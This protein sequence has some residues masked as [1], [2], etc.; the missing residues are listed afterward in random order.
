[1]HLT[2]RGDKPKCLFALWGRRMTIAVLALASAIIAPG[3][4]KPSETSPK[5]PTGAPTESK[6]ASAGTNVL[7]ISMDTTRADYLGCYGHPGV[8]TPHIDRLASQGTLFLNCTASVPVT[9]PSH[10]SIMTG[11][12]PFVHGVRDNGPFQLHANNVTLAEVLKQKGYATAAE[13]GAFV[14]N[15]EFGLDQGFDVYKDIHLAE[16][17]EEDPRA[18]TYTERRAEEISSSAIEWL[19]AHAGGPFFLFVHYFDPHH[20]HDP[21]EEFASQYSDLYLA[22]IAYTDAQIGRLLAEL[23]ALALSDKTLVVLVG[24]HGEGRGQHQENTHA[25]YVYDSTLQVPLIFRFPG[26]I[27]LGQRLE[28]QT[29]LVDVAPTIL[30][31]LGLE[32]LPNAQGVSLMPLIDRQTDDLGLAAYGES[33]YGKYGL[34]YSQLRTLR[35][36][37]WK[38]IHAPRPE[39]YH[40]SVDPAELHNLAADEPERVAR[41]REQLRRLIEDAPVVVGPDEARHQLT[42]E[43]IDKLQALGY[44]ADASAAPMGN[45][46][47]QFEPSGPNPM[48]HADEILLVNDAMALVRH[49][50]PPDVEKALRAVLEHAGDRQ[51]HLAWV[52]ASLGTVLA[53]Q[54]KFEE[55]IVC[56]RKALQVTPED[57]R[58]WSNLGVALALAGHVDEAI[59]AH[60]KALTIEPIFARSHFHM[61]VALTFKGRDEEAIAHHKKALEMNPRLAHAHRHLGAIYSRAGRMEEAIAEYKQAVELAPDRTPFRHELAGLLLAQRRPAEALPHYQKLVEAEPDRA[62]VHLGMG[63]AYLMLGRPDEA[64]GCF[65]RAVELEPQTAAAHLALAEASRQLGQLDQAV[66]GFRRAVE[67]DA[68]NARAADEL[69]LLLLERHEDA[70]AIR[71]LHDGLSAHPDHLNMANN[72]A[73][74]LATADDATLRDGQQA[75]ELAERVCDRT[76]RKDPKLLDTLAAAYAEAGRF[77]E[78]VAAADRALE[79]AEQANADDLVSK[80]KA[81]R[82][83]YQSRQAYRSQQHASSDVSS[84]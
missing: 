84:N 40:V 8:R 38:Y 56:Y 29:R 66:E 64:L 21:P 75:V 55:A 72:L 80:I 68:G 35:A 17:P 24:D 33:F 4:C 28:A 65:R 67:L 1:M 81:R 34:G 69:G 11:T 44:V 13:V 10:S 58:T 6:P 71:V 37:G 70:E 41:M 59:L 14:L 26:R 15:R 73:W 42:L 61:G 9:A 54:E 77:E 48:D 79:L 19:R 2:F 27:R 25:I 12:Y 53:A 51:A 22:E 7:L 31:F 20:P 32:A 83:L 76:Q 74:L 47:D 46:L 16:N 49:G 30:D 5:R 23:E 60:E 50:D 18:W 43:Q 39:L 3:G 57:G 45:E 63:R 82:H 52:N 36:G 78:A 62:R